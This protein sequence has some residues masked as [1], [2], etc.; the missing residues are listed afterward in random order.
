MPGLIFINQLTPITYNLDLDV[1]DNILE[2]KPKR[3]NEGKIIPVAAFETAARKQKEKIVYSGFIAQDVEMIARQ[4]GYNFSGID[5]ARSSKDLY[6]LRYAEFVVPLVKAVQELS[7]E[8][9]ELKNQSAVQ[10]KEMEKLVTR[11][12]KLEGLVGRN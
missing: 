1:V 5:A 6:G 11:M 10:M 4:I 12:E 3:D 7:Q 2:A 9:E 8:N